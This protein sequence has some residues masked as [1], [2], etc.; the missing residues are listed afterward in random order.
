MVNAAVGDKQHPLNTLKDRFSEFFSIRK[1]HESVISLAKAKL[2]EHS[3]WAAIHQEALT[4]L[5]TGTAPVE[6]GT[7]GRFYEIAVE[8]AS[9]V[10][11]AL[12]DLFS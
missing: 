5:L 6:R 4:L 11:V 12:L 1:Q 3:S 7:S 9:V 2:S 8:E 10:A